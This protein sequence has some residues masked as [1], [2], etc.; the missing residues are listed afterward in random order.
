MPECLVSGTL[1][2]EAEY[3]TALAAIPGS[4][5]KTDGLAVG[6]EAAAAILALRAADGSNQPLVDSLYPQ[7]DSPGEYRFTPDLPFAFAPNW[8]KVTPFALT[9]SSQFRPGAPYNV[10][11]PK[12]TADFN[13]V[14][15]L[16][17]QAPTPT[18]RTLAQ[19][20]TGLF[21][22]ESSPFAWNRIARQ[23]AETRGL[24]LWENARL[25][26]LL[27]LALADGYI[28]SWDTK[29]H[30]NFWRPV[31]AIRLA[32][33][34]G[35]PDTV[36]DPTWTP[37]ILTYPMPDY[38]SAHSVEGGAAAQVLAD[39]FGTD[40]IPFTACSFTLP[41]GKRCGQA[42]A[43]VRLYATFSEAAAENAESRILIG[44]HFRDAVEAGV[45]HGRKIGQFPVRQH[46]RP[47]R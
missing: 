11:T 19:T 29:F 14:K 30:F 44:I 15:S 28:A 4:A 41:L 2:V 25:F 33:D 10:T 12:Y 32:D 47:L 45:Q 42:G 36:G 5:A 13:E 26:G 9:R 38:D 22:V 18:D 16:G 20:E 37:L 1:V 27:N 7:G 24:D 46:L 17:G 35:N 23:V 34:D 40:A 3:A 6:H 8:G 31:T 39:F 43:V 21:W